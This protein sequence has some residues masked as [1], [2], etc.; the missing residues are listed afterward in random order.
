MTVAVDSQASH[1]LPK[2]IMCIL[3]QK[4]QTTY[5]YNVRSFFLVENLLGF[6]AGTGDWACPSTLE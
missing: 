2:S 5:F 4:Q 3:V 1:M 6:L